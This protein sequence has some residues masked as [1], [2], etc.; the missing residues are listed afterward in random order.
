MSRLLQK[1]HKGVFTSM[2]YVLFLSFDKTSRKY[3]VFQLQ[4]FCSNNNFKKHYVLYFDNIFFF[5]QIFSK[6][7]LLLCFKIFKS[8]LYK[9]PANIWWLV[10][11]FTSCFQ[12]KTSNWQTQRDL[13][14]LNFVIKGFIFPFFGSNIPRIRE[15]IRYYAQRNG[16]H[17][18]VHVC[19]VIAKHQCKWVSISLK[20]LKQFIFFI[21]LRNY[22][23]W[24]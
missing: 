8:K 4:I 24:L 22:T 17:K 15:K 20:I 14:N 6:N 2:I 3:R 18:Y 1:G 16:L 5:F 12:P 21:W 11:Y 19:K 10:G 23:V 9:P 13:M 7:L